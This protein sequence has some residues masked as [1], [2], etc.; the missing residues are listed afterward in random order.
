MKIGEVFCK[1]NLKEVSSTCAC[2]NY[3]IINYFLI[4]S[5]KN[6]IMSSQY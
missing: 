1:Q 3:F 6:L 4:K 5:Y 2:I